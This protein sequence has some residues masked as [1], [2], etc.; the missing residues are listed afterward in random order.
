MRRILK[1]SPHDGDPRRAI[2]YEQRR[3]NEISMHN[4][5]FNSGGVRYLY[6]PGIYQKDPNYRKDYEIPER[7]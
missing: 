4:L 5:R 6:C 2:F 1:F 3:R 7:P